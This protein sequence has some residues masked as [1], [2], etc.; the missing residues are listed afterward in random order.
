MMPLLPPHRQLYYFEYLIY[1][2]QPKLANIHH[3][4]VLEFWP[5]RDLAEIWRKE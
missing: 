2:A 5:G 1:G 3:R 4:G